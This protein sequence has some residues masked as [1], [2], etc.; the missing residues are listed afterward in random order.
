MTGSGS[1]I[2]STLDQFN[3][4]YQQVTGDCTIVARLTSLT[5]PSAFTQSGVMFRND[6]TTQSAMAQVKLFVSGGAWFLYRPAANS[7]VSGGQLTNPSLA[8]SQKPWFKVTRRGNV[9]TGY[10]RADDS[11]TW[12]QI[13][14]PATIPMNTTIYVGLD[15]CSHDNTQLATGTLDNVVI[16]AP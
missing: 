7:G 9:F 13:G 5:E 11:P 2:A 12:V 8:V 15:V 3:F 10:A 1:Q 4:A 16:T 14:N 6:L